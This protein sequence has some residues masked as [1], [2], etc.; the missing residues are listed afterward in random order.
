VSGNE[1]DPDL[2]VDLI[3]QAEAINAVLL[4]AYEQVE[5]TGFY[6]RGYNPT[7]RLYDKSASIY[8]KP[9]QD[10]LQYFYPRITGTE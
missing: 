10:L 1:V 6:V 9:A 5:I 2:G 4:G 3:A 7:A 8:G